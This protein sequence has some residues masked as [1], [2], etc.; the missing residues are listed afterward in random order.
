ME[1]TLH[2]GDR[3]L[4]N[5]LSYKLHDVHRGDVVVFRRPE[6]A[7]S[8]DDD[9]EDLIKR[10]IGLPGDTVETVDGVIYVNGEPLPEPYLVK[11]TRSDSPPVQR[12]VI[13]KDHYFVMGD[14]RGNSQ[15]SRFF[16]PIDGGLIVGR[17]FWR[18]Y[19]LDDIGG[20]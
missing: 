12:Q 2:E 11:G 14:N 19:P 8:G 18:I 16:G 1:P 7:E 13:P 15:D 9:I 10:V 6:G 17:A 20:L 4:V 3:V 5:K